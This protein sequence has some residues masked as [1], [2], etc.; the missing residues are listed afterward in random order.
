MSQYCQIALRN[1]GK[2]EGAL[3]ERTCYTMRSYVMAG[4]DRHSNSTQQVGYSVCEPDYLRSMTM[5]EINDEISCYRSTVSSQLG[6]INTLPKLPTD[7]EQDLR[8]NFHLAVFHRGERARLIPISVKP[9]ALQ[10]IARESSARTAGLNHFP[11]PG[12]T[13]STLR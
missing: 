8:P 3:S 5:A 6:T 4:E 10:A 12:K 9:F 2:W 13:Q 7:A 1:P 11:S